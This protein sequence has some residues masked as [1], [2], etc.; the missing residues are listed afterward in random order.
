[1]RIV[2]GTTRLSASDEAN[3]LACR[4]LTRLDRLE[5]LGAI[6]APT[7][8]DPGFEAL[9]RRGEI[10]EAEVLNDFRS[11]GLDIVEIDRTSSGAQARTKVALD[12][13]VA[14]IYQPTLIAEGVG[15]EPSLIGVPDFLV[16]ADLLPE[17]IGNDTRPNEI[18]Y[19]VVDAKLA[20]SAKARAVLQTAFYS[21]LLGELQSV[22]PTWMHLALGSGLLLPFRVSDFAAYERRIR[23]LLIEFTGTDPGDNPPIDP[24][25]DPVEHCAIC[26]WS[27][28]CS[29]RRRSDDH[30]S[31]VAGLTARQRRALEAVGVNTRRGLAG[32]ATAPPL[33]RISEDSLRKA[34]LQAR[35]QVSSEDKGILCYEILEPD[36]DDEGD[37]VPNRGL[38]ALPEPSI[39][40]LFFDIEGARYYSEDGKEFGLQYLFGLV[41]TADVDDDGRPRYTGLW[42]FDRRG[43]GIAFEELIDFITERRKRNPRLHVYHYNHYEPTSVDHLSELHETREEAVGRLMGRF[44]TREDEVDDLFRLGVFVDLYR[45]VKQ[46]VRVG[47]ESYSIK[48]LEPLYGFTRAVDLADATENLIAFENCLEEGNALADD[49]GVRSAIQGYNEDDCRSTLGLRDWLEGRRTELASRLGPEL[50]RPRIE[51]EA[52]AREDPEVTRIRSTL[53]GSVGADPLVWTDQESAK[54]L[55]ADLLD[56]H[57]REAKPAWW[58]YFRVRSMTDQ[59]LLGEPDALSGLM[60]GEMVATIKRSVVLRFMFPPQDHPFSEGDSAI[61]PVTEKQWTVWSLDE[62]RGSID[63]KIG[64]TSASALPTALVEGAPFDTRQLALR[65]R[66]LGDRVCR[67]GVTGGDAA[68]ALL[69]RKRPEGGDEQSSLLQRPGE[70]VTEAAVRLSLQLTRSYLP[71]Q[72]PPGSGKTY[73]GATQIVE[74]VAQGRPVGIT[75]PSHAVIHNLIE[76]VLEEARLRGMTPR[77]GQRAEDDNP[78]LHSKARGMK[79]GEIETGLRSGEIDIGAGTIWMWARDQF[80]ESVET[81]FVDEAAQM[82]LANVLAVAGAAHNVVLL[83]DPQQLAQPSQAAHPPGAQVSALEYILRDGATMPSDAGLF[84]DRT[85]RLHPDLCAYTSEMFYDGRLGWVEGLDRQSVGDPSGPYGTGLRVV[86]VAH[87]GNASE[88]SEEAETVARLVQALVAEEWID[89]NGTATAMTSRDVLVVAPY[90]AQV[91]EIDSALAA[92][93]ITGV[94][95]GTVDKFQGRQA[96][97]VVYSMATSSAD[98]APRGMEFLYDRHRLNVATSRARALAIIVASPQLVRVYCRTPRQMYLANA[99]CAAWEA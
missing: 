41:D 34:L 24:Y 67:D 48:R 1:V 62:D 35:L 78:Y 89:A 28:L 68:T 37:L 70:T 5:A 40:D 12:S 51:E 95:V 39:G 57:R 53:L 45:V 7:A 42:S 77:I 21:S 19:E 25:P 94:R 97:A 50:P 55:L 82:S 16:R 87:E 74:F 63:L 23:S 91:R 66:E 61:D 36:R 64:E 32:L 46:G 83:G 99:L 22:K 56:W 54:A 3:F 49:A 29:A 31:L 86:P 44:A 11:Q 96:P 38:L 73:T 80:R 47:V 43:E 60:G 90:N 20:R 18:H 65:L 27:P 76:G 92:A 10:H 72:G 33:K 69:L 2:N 85:W 4:H 84:L 9:V 71:I 17:V 8:V 58:R 13:G 14:V 93:G 30:L 15:T 26:R 6:S 81:L 75:G 59:E 79:Y 98:L 88:S 52:H